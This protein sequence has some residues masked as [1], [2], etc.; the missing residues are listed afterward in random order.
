MNR[1]KLIV[2]G[3]L[4][5][6]VA[7]SQKSPTNEKAPETRTEVRENQVE[8]PANQKVEERHE[9]LEVQ[10]K[11]QTGGLIDQTSVSFG[12]NQC[13]FGIMGEGGEKTYAAS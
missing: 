7:C 12:G 4:A 3:G 8:E 1:T 2:S 11:N 5:V 6:L 10:L 13:T 9:Y